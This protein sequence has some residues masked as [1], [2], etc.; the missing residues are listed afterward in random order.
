MLSTIIT[1]VVSG[2][3]QRRMGQVWRAF[4]L[5]ADPCCDLKGSKIVWGTSDVDWGLALLVTEVDVSACFAEHA[6]T[7]CI[8]YGGCKV[9]ST[10]TRHAQVSTN[11]M[12]TRQSSH[13]N[14]VHLLQENA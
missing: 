13:V 7:L 12:Q 10:A 14:C 8:S 2:G 6:G 3:D 9:Q 5:L 1:Q 4:Q 11:C